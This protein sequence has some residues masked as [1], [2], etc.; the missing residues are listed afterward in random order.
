MPFHGLIPQFK[1]F[2]AVKRQHHRCSEWGVLG[3]REASREDALSS[4]WLPLARVVRSS[5]P[6]R[7]V[8]RSSRRL[9]ERKRCTACEELRGSLAVFST[10]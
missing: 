10:Y 1:R 6:P 9:L 4:R 7:D 2:H 3:C 5:K 8:D